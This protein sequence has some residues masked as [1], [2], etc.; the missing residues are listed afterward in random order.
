VVEDKYTP[1]NEKKKQM[2]TFSQLA[3]VLA[4]YRNYKTTGNMD[5]LKK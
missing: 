2:T 3:G 4:V 1:I 5:A